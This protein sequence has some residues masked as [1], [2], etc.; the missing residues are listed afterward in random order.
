MRLASALLHCIDHAHAYSRASTC[1]W[2]FLMHSPCAHHVRRNSLM[3]ITRTGG[4][5]ELLRRVL[6]FIYDWNEWTF[7]MS[8]EPFAF[9]HHVFLIPYTISYVWAA[10]WALF[11]LLYIFLLFFHVSGNLSAWERYCYRFGCNFCLPLEPSIADDAHT[12]IGWQA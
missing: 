8:R 2:R 6:Y 3:F 11:P 1:S 9:R 7:H 4:S 12:W 10:L 5:C